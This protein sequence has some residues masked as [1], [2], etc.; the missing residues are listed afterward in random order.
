MNV[1]DVLGPEEGIR[2]GLAGNCG[3]EVDLDQVLSQIFHLEAARIW[4]RLEIGLI[5]HFNTPS[6]FH[7]LRQSAVTLTQDCS[8]FLEA[9]L[10]DEFGKLEVERV[11]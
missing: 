5:L 7:S 2:D 1:L 10:V 8:W 3:F 9:L 4:Q 11:L 6:R